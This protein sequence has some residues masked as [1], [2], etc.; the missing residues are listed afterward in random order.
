MDELTTLLVRTVIVYLLLTLSMRIMGKRQLGEMEISDLITTLLFSEIAA[1]PVVDQSIP[2]FHAII[3]ILILISF[4]IIIPF[5]IGKSRKVKKLVEGRPS[6]LIYKGEL[7]L[8]EIKKNRVS[9]DEIMCE[10]RN[11]GYFDLSDVDYALLEPNGQLS[12]LPKSNDETLRNVGGM[13]HCLVING[14]IVRF[15]LSLVGVD[16]N[17]VNK[18]VSAMGARLS[19]VSL[20]GI[21]DNGCVIYAISKNGKNTKIMKKAKKDV[22]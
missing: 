8:S 15:N 5:A 7:R 22:P 3:P 9:L 20:L 17:W 4:E 13:M 19:D 16:E 14:E 2:L 6:Y 18:T 12:V 1:V 10:L 21:D 11:Q